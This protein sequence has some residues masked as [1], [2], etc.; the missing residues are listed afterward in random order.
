MFSWLKFLYVFGAIGLLIFYS[1]HLFSQQKMNLDTI[2]TVNVALKSL[3]IGDLR[4]GLSYSMNKRDVVNELILEVVRVQ[5]NHGKD[6]RISYA[7]LDYENKITE[8]ENEIFG[9]QFRVELLNKNG[10]VESI[11]EQRQILKGDFYE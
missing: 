3:N 8:N 4:N 1:N 11:S 5:K 2:Q 10:E 6:L 7:F 9:I